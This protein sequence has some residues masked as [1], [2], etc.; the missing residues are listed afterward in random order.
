MRKID[1]HVHSRIYLTKEEEK[2]VLYRPGTEKLTYATPEQIQEFYKEL[3]VEKGVLLLSEAPEGM[4]YTSTNQEAM[5]IIRK[6][7]ELF[8]WF[9]SI[10]PRCETN[11]E[12]TDLSYYINHFKKYGAKGIG[13][14]TVKLPFLDDRMQNL[15]RHAEICEMPLLF[16]VGTDYSSYGIYDVLGL[17]QLE[18]TL[19]RFPKLIFIGH[20]Q[21]FW[22]EIGAGI[23]EK[24]RDGYPSGPVK[25]TGRVVELMRKYNNLHA[26]LSANSGY[27]AVTRDPD[28]GYA[29]L[30]EFKDRIYYGTDICSS[31]KEKSFQLSDF[32]DRGL[33]Q[34]KLSES[35]YNKIC[36]ENAL[37]ILER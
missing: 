23:E 29:F 31:R 21:P 13:E 18:E 34:N 4:H 20:S 6:Y 12:D 37:R 32:L 10:D 8:Y 24:D 9:C 16:H 36:R 5:R 30:E 17:K 11:R 2:S 33:E 26:D 25:K 19:I 27:N 1:I 35:A 3:G 14:V 15:F 22:A 28:F 7:P